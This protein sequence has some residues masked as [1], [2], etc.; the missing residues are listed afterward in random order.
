M[1]GVGHGLVGPYLVICR[2]YVEMS[3]L[4]VGRLLFLHPVVKKVQIEGIS[5]T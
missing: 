3:A 2:T 4:R 1:V 5:V